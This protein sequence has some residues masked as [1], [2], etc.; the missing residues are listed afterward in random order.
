MRIRRH[1]DDLPRSGAATPQPVTRLNASR[2]GRGFHAFLSLNP[3][4][5]PIPA[6]RP[7]EGTSGRST[8]PVHAGSLELFLVNLRAPAHPPLSVFSVRIRLPGR[9]LRFDAAYSL[10]RLACGL[11]PTTATDASDRG[12]SLLGSLAGEGA[13]ERKGFPDSGVAA[14]RL[15]R[16]SR[17]VGNTLAS[18]LSRERTRK[19]QA[20]GGPSRRRP[21]WVPGR[22]LRSDVPTDTAPATWRS[23][24]QLRLEEVSGPPVRPVEVKP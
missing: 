13:T 2:T 4:T 18:E 23:R 12:S 7:H 8:G 21:G 22:P 20:R 11:D 5:S 1:R 3:R 9:G 6:L 16:R 10:P 15:I 24:D 17:P 14:C 19:G